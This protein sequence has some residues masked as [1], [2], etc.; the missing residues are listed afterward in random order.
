MTGSSPSVD[1]D[2]FRRLLGSFASGV[3]VVTAVD[4][5]G[6][7]AG[8]T[9]SAV[10]S[11]SLDPPLMLACVAK[12][13]EFHRAMRDAPGFAVHVLRADQADLSRR[14]AVKGGDKFAGSDIVLEPGR[15]PLLR[16]ALARIV[17]ERY[18]AFEAGD[19]TIFLGRVTGGDAMEGEPLLHF[20]G[21]YRTSP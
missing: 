2:T 16:S 7:P 1:A 19:H 4:A 11:V 13:A 14:F 21:V 15:P 12:D 10:A 18:G 9:A 5:A 6:A 8:M 3:T 17:C 20:R